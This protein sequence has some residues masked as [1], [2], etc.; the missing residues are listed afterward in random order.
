MRAAVAASAELKAVPSN[1][2]PLLAAAADEQK[3]KSFNGCL[4]T[5]NQS[6]Q[7]ECAT[8]DTASTTTVALIGD[9]HAAMWNPAFQQLAGQR[10]WRL[11]MMA[12]AA[13]PIL[14]LPIT[15]AYSHREDTECEQWRGQ[16]LARLRAE[17]PRLIMV[18]LWRAYGAISRV[19][20]L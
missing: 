16:I 7:P 20:A 11:E 3:P 19:D 5:T 1:L 4:R 2:Q 14:D 10:P 12:K 6:D 13:C 17:H 8:G 18:G 9:S 15:N